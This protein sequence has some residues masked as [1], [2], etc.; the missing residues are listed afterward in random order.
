[1]K[2]TIRNIQ[3][4]Q[5]SLRA[6]IDISERAICI[7]SISSPEGTLVHKRFVQLETGE[8]A[9]RMPVVLLQEGRYILTLMKG[10]QVAQ[11]D[12]FF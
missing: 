11:E 12:F 8:N 7:V 3:V 1:M 9:F 5:E 10:N 6:H 4:E 2:I